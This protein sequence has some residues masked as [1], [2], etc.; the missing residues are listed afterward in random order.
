VIHSDAV[1]S[2]NAVSFVQLSLCMNEHIVRGQ[3][4]CAWSGSDHLI[5]SRIQNVKKELEMITNKG[6]CLFDNK[7]FFSI[8][9]FFFSVWSCK[10][11]HF[12]IQPNRVHW[13]GDRAVMTEICGMNFIFRLYV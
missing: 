6:K 11:A 9:C 4:I 1:G 3:P 7:K 2:A 13:I 12:S 8:L 10:D 5:A